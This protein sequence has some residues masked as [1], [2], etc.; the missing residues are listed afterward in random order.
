[1]TNLYSTKNQRIIKAFFLPI[2][3]SHKT[4]GFGTQKSLFCIPKQALFKLNKMSIGLNSIK[5]NK[6]STN[7]SIG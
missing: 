2:A 4:I 7:F 5:G 3:L 1:M 6:F